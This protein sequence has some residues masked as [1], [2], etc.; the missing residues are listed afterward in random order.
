MILR[1][2]HSIVSKKNPKTVLYQVEYPFFPIDA[3]VKYQIIFKINQHFKHF[4]KVE[5]KELKFCEPQVL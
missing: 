2:Y 3:L 5:Q 1:K 4:K